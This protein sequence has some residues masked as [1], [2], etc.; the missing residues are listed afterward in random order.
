MNGVALVLLVSVCALNAFAAEGGTKG[1]YDFTASSTPAAGEIGMQ[2]WLDAPAGRHGRI[3]R[4]GQDLYYNGSPIKLWGLNLCYSAC[5]PSRELADKQAAFYAKYGVNAVRLHKYADGPGWAGIQTED[6]FAAFVPEK[7][8]RMDYLV[9][10]LKEHGIYSCLSA[11]FGSIKVGPADLQVVPY[12]TE[13]GDLSE[14]HNRIAA[15][16]SALFYS[17]ELQQLHIS[18]TVNLLR[19]RNPHTGLTYAEEPAISSIEIINEQSILFYTSMSPLKASP[20]L[21]RKVGN[22][23]CDWLR[24]RYGDREGLM[25]AWGQEA[26]GAFAGEGFPEAE[27]LEHDSILPLG[28]PYYWHPERL[29]GSHKHLRQRLLDTL[30]FLYMLQVQAYQRFAQ[31]VRAEGYDGEITG[32][33]WQAGSA[34]S[35]YGNLHTDSLVGTIDRHNYFGGGKEDQFNNSSLLPGAGSGMLSTGMQQVADRPFMLSEWIHVYPNEWGAE[36]PAV[37]GAYGMGL[38][39]WDVSYMFQNRDSGGFSDLIGR[40]RWD[41]TAPQ[42]MGTFPAVARMVLRGDVAQSD[43]EAPRYVHMPSLFEGKL[44]FAD[45][46]EQ[47]YD[48]KSFT[49]EPVPSRALAVARCTVEFTDDSRSTPAFDL[50]PYNRDGALVSTTGELRWFEGEGERDGYFTLN[51]AGTK[52]VVGF[53]EGERL[54]LGPVTIQPHCRFGAIY[55]TAQDRRQDIASAD[56]LLIVVM[57]RARNTGMRLNESQDAVLEKGRPP[58]VLEPVKASIR[59]DRPG[60]RVELLDH[61]GLPT[62]EMLAAQDGEFVIDGSRDETPYYLVRFGH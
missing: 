2:S 33:N 3:L 56:K 23:F 32:S 13:F 29:H 10:R 52:A 58:V 37:I 47:G 5:C 16:H 11:H 60:V 8:E 38:Q 54:S 9:A 27:S 31:A 36:G 21:R 42:V 6:S 49:S 50:S 34:F 26:L 57:A 24:E 61:D 4:R 43:V 12:A 14:R 25:A 51:T 53:A 55:I 44:G 35:H 62:G 30:Q 22:R 28:N 19:H 17:P 1:W 41:V 18:Q 45:T 20:T 59:I 15:P 7:L 40:E 39:G 48:V 46:A